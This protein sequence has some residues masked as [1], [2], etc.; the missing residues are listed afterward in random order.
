MIDKLRSELQAITQKHPTVHPLL[1]DELKKRS[2][3]S[4]SVVCDSQG[5]PLTVLANCY[6]YAFELAQFEEYRGIRR[7]DAHEGLNRFIANSV[8]VRHLVGQGILTEHSVPLE[9][10]LVLYFGTDKPEHAG[11]M[12]SASRVTSKWGSGHL[13]EHELWEVPSSY[14]DD[15][16]FFERPDPREVFAAFKS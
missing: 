5:L 11:L 6:E 14:S 9:G 13:W 12:K 16:Q 1:V 8:L 15:V 7:C 2:P 10:A 3:H 4:V